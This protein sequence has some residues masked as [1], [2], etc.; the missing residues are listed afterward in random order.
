[1]KY[2]RMPTKYK[3]DQLLTIQEIAERW[4]CSQLTVGYAIQRMEKTEGF[5]PYKK[6]CKK[7]KGYGTIEKF[8]LTA[9]QVDKMRYTI[10]SEQH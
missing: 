8:A 9:E 6:E 2:K 1:M 3:N 10:E 4:G 7:K 5:I